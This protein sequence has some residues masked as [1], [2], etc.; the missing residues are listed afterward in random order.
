MATRIRH[1]FTLVEL[2]LVIA[3]IGVLAA[4]AIPRLSRGASGAGDAALESDLRTLRQAALFYCAE[5]GGKYP[6]G[7]EADVIAKLTG[8]SNAAGAT[9]PKPAAGYPLGP[10][11]AKIPPVPVGPRTGSTG[12]LIDATNSPP[13]ADTSKAKGW[14]YNPNTG[15]FV[16]NV[17]D[18]VTLGQVGGQL[19][20]Q[21]DVG[22]K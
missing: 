21:V 19:G 22:G 5:H 13:K 16:A 9:S 17:E 2:T 14:V 15:E 3:I 18:G 1:G 11:L 20:G 12:I 10:Y 6:S 7:A 8:Y 4:I